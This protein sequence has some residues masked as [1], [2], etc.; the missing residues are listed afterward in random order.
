[1][2]VHHYR[3]LL[4]VAL[5]LTL[6]AGLTTYEYVVT[7]DQ[8]VMHVWTRK[9]STA[10]F[11]LLSI[12]WVMVLIQIINN[13]PP[14]IF[15]CKSLTCVMHAEPSILIHRCTVPQVLADVFSLY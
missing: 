11:L 7:F 2:S 6:N 9:P 14:N 13:V 10:S 4:K 5:K 3:I 15:K 8:E 12:R 1:M